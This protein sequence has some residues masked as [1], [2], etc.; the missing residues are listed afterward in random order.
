MR[1]SRLTGSRTACSLA[2]IFLSLVVHGFQAGALGLY[3]DDSGQLLQAFE[4]LQHHPL[5]FVLTDTAGSLPSERPFAF[6]AFALTRLAFLDGVAAVHWLLVV[7]LTVNALAIAAVARR[8]VGHEWFAFAVA[9]IFLT[10]PLAPLQPLWPATVHYQVA[11]LL[12][13][14]SI[15]CLDRTT[16]SRSE[17]GGRWLVA[18]AF[19]YAG[20]VTTH[21]G[22]AL[23][24]PAYFVARWAWAE[25]G[26]RSVVT[27]RLLVLV[28]ILMA[29]GFWRIALLPRYGRQMYGLSSDRMAP[30]AFALKAGQTVVK[31]SY[32]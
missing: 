11:C 3:W 12:A 26:E 22:L 31:A 9:A 20:A 30:E 8:L 29:A 16:P 32:P 4:A 18:G 28:T 15:L 19:A 2:V 10:Y 5:A 21:E 13:L 25:A 27:G 24:P 7:L 1:S 14:A 17:R 6:F 23:V